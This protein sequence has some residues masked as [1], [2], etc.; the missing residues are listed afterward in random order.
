[1][2]EK[3]W[4]DS[5]QEENTFIIHFGPGVIELLFTGNL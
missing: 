2:A 3:S 4:F 5:W 1:M